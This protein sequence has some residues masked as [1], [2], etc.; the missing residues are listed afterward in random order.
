MRLTRAEGTSALAPTNT[1]STIT[2][3]D[4]DTVNVSVEDASSLEGDSG[5][6][7]VPVTVRLDRA[8]SQDITLNVETSIGGGSAEAGDFVALGTDA[9]VTV[10]AGSLT[11]T[12]DVQFNGD[13]DDNEG[14][15]TFTVTI[16]LPNNPIERGSN[17]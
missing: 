2:I 10:N 1:T 15:E 5:T 11:G 4:S 17:S 13:T 12:F 14:D 8:S 6:K 9:T 7:D 3:N 16:S